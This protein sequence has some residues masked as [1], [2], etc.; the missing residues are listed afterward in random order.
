[1]YPRQEDPAEDDDDDNVWGGGD[2]S[3]SFD[4]G[5]VVQRD[6]PLRNKFKSEVELKG[7]AIL[8][9]LSKAPLC[10]HHPPP[11]PPVSVCRSG[12]MLWVGGGAD[13][14]ECCRCCCMHVLVLCM[15]D[16]RVNP[17]P[18]TVSVLRYDVNRRRWSAD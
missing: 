11:P 12:R 16:G 10:Q 6:L 8:Y 5:G 7:F 3:G 4:G 15:Y 18:Q 17:V 9:I 2:G 13:A 1:M 14:V